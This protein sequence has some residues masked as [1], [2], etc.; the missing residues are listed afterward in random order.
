M[1]PTGAL[2]RA[3]KQ[4]RSK[5]SFERALDAVVELL[6]ERG[7]DAFTLADVATRAGVS[8]GSIYTRVDSKENLIRSAHER[9]MSRLVAEGEAALAAPPSGSGSFR[10]LVGELIGQVGEHLRRNAA[11]LRAFMLVAAHDETI[12]QGGKVSYA[13]ILEL[14]NERLGARR[15]EIAHPDPD[16]ATRWAYTVT[17]SVIARH[18]G[19]G[20]AEKADG[21]DWDATL[22][23]LTV[24]VTTYLTAPA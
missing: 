15:D 24:M 6:A 8:T 11:L 19:L 20:T 4:E 13:R 10:E 9:E 5:I 21:G 12:A 17:Y 3:P 2:A 14:W 23:N 7:S 1:N 18:L 16:A 22:A